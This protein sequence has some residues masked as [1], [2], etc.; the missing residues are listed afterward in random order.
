MIT[1]LDGKL[2]QWEFWYLFGENSSN[3][4]VEHLGG[5]YLYDSQDE[6]ALALFYS[7]SNQSMKRKA[8]FGLRF[9]FGPEGQRAGPG[10]SLSDQELSLL[11]GD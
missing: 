11:H 8:T 7:N 5:G 1:P 6:E 10:R 4:G 9:M 2:L 3:F